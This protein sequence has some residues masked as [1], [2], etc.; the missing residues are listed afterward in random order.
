MSTVGQMLER[1]KS[2]NVN[3]EVKKIIQSDPKSYIE[4][5]QEQLLAGMG[6]N[7][8]KLPPYRSLSYQK[9][10]ESLNPGAGGNPD[11]YLTGAMFA[12]MQIEIKND[13][14]RI[15][16]TVPYYDDLIARGG[17]PFGLNSEA[18]S[19][20]IATTLYDRLLH[21]IKDQTGTK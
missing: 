17:D 21:A 20:Y 18:K 2:L 13:A 19:N 7:N 9:F 10:K 1:F 8:S 5:N 15:F 3:E 16:S 4:Q 6:A 12:A 14:V 11:Y